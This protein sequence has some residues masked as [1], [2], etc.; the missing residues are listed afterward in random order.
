MTLAMKLKK[1]RLLRKM[2]TTELSR[3][4]GIHQTTISALENN[5]HASPG[6]DTVERL[7][8]ALRVSPL[9][10]FEDRVRTP[11]DLVNDLPSEISDFLLREESLPYL[12]LSKKAFENGIS[13]MTIEQLL[14]VLQETYSTSK[15]RGNENAKERK[16]KDKGTI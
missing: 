4:S 2:S 1:L 3:I 5:K 9:Y 15:T 8:R 10:F 16:R 6:I 13:S 12:M 14:R 7:A 11:F